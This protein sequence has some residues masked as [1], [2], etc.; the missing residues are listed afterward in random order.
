M[1]TAQES[2]HIQQ[3]KLGNNNA[4]QVLYQ[5]HHK[6]IIK[7]G[8]SLFPNNEDDVKDAYQDVFLS[9]W[10]ARERV[11]VDITL[12][13]YLRK[14]IKNHMIQLKKKKLRF[15]ELPND[16]DGLCLELQDESNAL[17]CITEYEDMAIR[18]KMYNQKLNLLTKRQRFLFTE[19]FINEKSVENIMKEQK[20]AR[21]TVYNTICRCISVLKTNQKYV[22][23]Y[24]N[25]K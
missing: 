19:R 23:K 4:F 14:S 17:T 13:Y 2:Y 25:R 20:L 5:H 3:F 22:N 9:L 10:R 15:V 7:Y 16:K 6:N 18:T 12:D 21:Q 1:T 11:T 8:K 24:K